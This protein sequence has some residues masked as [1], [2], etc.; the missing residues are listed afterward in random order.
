MFIVCRES[1]EWS[2]PAYPILTLYMVDRNIEV[3]KVLKES[4]F[5]FP[6]RK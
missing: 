3:Y 6:T 2:G 1:T 5:W 4:I